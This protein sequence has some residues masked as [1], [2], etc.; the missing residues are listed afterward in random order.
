MCLW[1]EKAYDFELYPSGRNKA[2]AATYLHLIKPHYPDY[3]RAVALRFKK[4]PAKV[5]PLFHEMT[6]SHLLGTQEE[7]FSG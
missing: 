6:N 5:N 3:L 2:M 7:L 4:Y 1:T